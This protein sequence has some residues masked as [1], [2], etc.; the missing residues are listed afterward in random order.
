MI[1]IV[2]LDLDKYDLKTIERLYE[3]GV[4]TLGEAAESKAV[5]ELTDLQKLQW[6]RKEQ[7]ARD[8]LQAS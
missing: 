1:V 7:R 2:R 3:N 6:C 5:K 8:M 4:I